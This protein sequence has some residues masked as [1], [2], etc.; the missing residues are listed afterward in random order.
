MAGRL[1]ERQAREAYAICVDECGA[2]P[3]DRYD[4]HAFIDY[5]TSENPLEWRF[6]GSLG[7]GGKLYFSRWNGLHVG[8]YRENETEERISAME[9]ANQRLR[10]LDAGRQALKDGA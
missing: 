10:D 1:T 8:C 5:A 9:R 4:E 3:L 7:F 2:R 6:M